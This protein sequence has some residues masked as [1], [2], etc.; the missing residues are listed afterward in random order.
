MMTLQTLAHAIDGQALGPDVLFTS[1]GTDSR[2]I[3]AG[4][5]FIAL[6]GEKFDGHRFVEQALRDGA[7][8]ALV[9]DDHGAWQTKPH[10]LVKDT[11]LALG[12]LGAY[13]RGQFSCPLIGVTG[14]SGKTTV[15]E[16]LAAILREE[17]GAYEA[18]LATQ[19]NLNNDIGMPL[20]LLRL[21][22]EH[23][24]AVIEMGMNHAGEIRYLTH[25]AKPTVTVINNAG[26]AHIGE[27]GSLE[28][29]AQAK[30]EILEGLASEGVAVLNADDVFFSFWSGL[31]KGKRLLTFG[32]QA[33][34]DVTASY[35]LE[36]EAVKL[37]L[38]TP[39]GKGE[40]TLLAPGLHNV[41]NALAASA[42]ALAAG[43]SLDSVCAGL[44]AYRGIK[45]RLQVKAGVNNS[46][47]I[48]DTYNANPVSMKAA[49]DVLAAYSGVR[50]FVMGDMGELGDTAQA[51][52]A[53][54]GAYAKQK[55][56][57]VLMAVGAHSRHAVEAFEGGHYFAD[58]ATL[59][60]ALKGLL[61]QG[62]TLLVKGSRFMAMEEV[63]KSMTTQTEGERH[64]T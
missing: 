63:V 2:A 59:C 27:L 54:V 33:S 61:S 49:I 28:A 37:V 46:V 4:Q 13:W 50:V 9:S 53:E 17:V 31:A 32:L 26:S 57:D 38:K 14:S 47:I 58:K 39:Y 30:G 20:T 21:R 34:A 35:Q 1:V 19:G 48:D 41:M 51:S 40:A 16:M 52:H 22:A 5:L 6:K 36:P 25:L 62:V 23:R 42:A 8:A 15:K 10:V 45:G 44:Q 43:V 3:E 18:V 64:A 55:G 29:I 60:H 7:S 11:R 56:I 12:Q 24:F